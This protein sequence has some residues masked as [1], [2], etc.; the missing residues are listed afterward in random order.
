MRILFL[1]DEESKSYWDFY[2]KEAFE[3]IDLIVSCGD[4]DAYY[5]I[6][7]TTMTSIPVLYVKGNHDI[8]MQKMRLKSGFLTEWSCVEIIFCDAE[9]CNRNYQ[10]IH[11]HGKV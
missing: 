3:G 2:Q 7:L 9:K 1:S 10:Q 5:L 8:L 11:V 6:F 4:L